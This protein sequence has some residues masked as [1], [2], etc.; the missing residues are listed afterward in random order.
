MKKII[1]SLL[2][3][4]S[5]LTLWSCKD[6]D[7]YDDSKVTYFVK[8][9]LKGDDVMSIAKGSTFTDPGAVATEGTEDISSKIAVTSDLDA[10]KVGVYTVTYTA[11]NVDGYSSSVSRTVAVYD[12]V[13]PT[14]DLA[15][16]YTVAPGTYRLRGEAKTAYSGQSVTIT[17]LASGV[18]AISDFL[19]GYYDQRAGYGSRYALTGY[20]QLNSDNTLTPISSYVAGW[21][22]SLSDLKDAKYDPSTGAISFD[23]VYA[24]MD[25]FITLTK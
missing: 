12:P 2:I 17:K 13:A 15:G 24:N 14:T 7:S 5:L 8:M 20:F 25:F 18:F 6:K 1:F 19:G 3:C 21:G 9:A 10:S 23:A 11:T 4:T 22:D 16:T